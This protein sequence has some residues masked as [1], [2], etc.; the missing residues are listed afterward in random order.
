MNIFL[1]PDNLIDIFFEKLSYDDMINFTNVNHYTYERYKH[2][3]K[4]MSFLFI[5]KDYLSFRKN[6][7]RYKYTK[8]ELLEL[9]VI[10]V[11]DI[12]RISP[13]SNGYIY[14][15]LRYLFELILLGLNIND[16]DFLIECRKKSPVCK[17]QIEFILR[18]IKGCVSFSRHET[19]HKI[20]FEPCLGVLHSLFEPNDK[21]WIYI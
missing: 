3:M 14:Y 7:I 1:L 16:S 10:G 2:K 5:N 9:G 19:I 15:D 17:N 13:I 20:N 18:K 21:N 11:K 12:Q 6:L 4:Q 8:K